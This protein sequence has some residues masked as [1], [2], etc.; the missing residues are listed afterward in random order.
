[1]LVLHIESKHFQRQGKAVANF[2]RTLPVPQ[3]DLSHQLLGDR[4][5]FDFLTLSADAHEREVK[6]RGRFPARAFSPNRD[7]L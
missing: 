2:Q 7:S 5:N 3:S 6:A 1:M 4:Y